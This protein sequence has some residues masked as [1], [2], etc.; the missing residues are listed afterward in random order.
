MTNK[1]NILEYLLC[2]SF[3]IC[4]GSS[5]GVAQTTPD[6]GIPGPYAV[7]KLEY[8]FGDLAYTPPPAAA[9]PANMEV[10]GSVHF[11]TNLSTGPYPVLLFLHGRHSTCWETSD[12]STALEWPCPT[13]W[14]SITSYEGYDYLARNMA[15]H[16]Y[17]VISISANAINAIDNTLPDDG[18][19]ARGVLVQHHLDLWNTWNTVGGAPFDTLFIGKLNMRNI[20]T[21][22]HSRGGEGVIYNAQYNAS[23]GSPYGIK[24]VL[25]LA[26][27]DFFRHVLNGI[28]LLDVAPYCDGDVSDLEGVHFYDDARYNDTND[29]APKHT[30]LFM[31]ADHDFFNTVWTPYLYPAGGADDWLYGF[32]STDPQ[33][34]PSAPGTKRLDTTTQQAALTAYLAAFYRIYIGHETQ[35]NPILQVSDIIP[36]ASSMLDS[37]QVFVSYHPA[38][39]DRLDVNRTDSLDRLTTNTLE[40]AV[41]ETGLVSSAICGGGLTMAT[42]DAGVSNDQ[43]PHRGTATIAGLGQM[44]MRWSDSAEWYQNALPVAYQNLTPYLT[45][46]FRASEDFKE[47]TTDTNV[48][49]TVQLVDSIGDTSNQVVGNHT[50]S[51]FYQPGTQPTDLPKEV[52][53]TISIPLS[54]FTGIDKTKVRYIRFKFN[55][56]GAGAVVISDLAFTNP[57]CGNFTAFFTDSIAHTGHKVFFTNQSTSYGQDS[58]VW[59]WNFGDA[60]S[61]VN[62]TS[63]QKSPFHIYPN[64]E[65][66]NPCLYVTSYRKNGLVCSDSFCTQA[67]LSVAVIN[68][69]NI[70]IMPNPAKDYIQVKGAAS[71]DVLT[72]I[73]L[74]GEVV[75]TATLRQSI[76]Q[77]PQNL[78]TGIYYAIVTTNTGRIYNKLLITR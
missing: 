5:R 49:F 75:L 52:F 24:A 25:T 34:G 29:E 54:T 26:P 35:F 65:S 61:G 23:L 59:K 38:R 3:F 71:T 78:A 62:D 10:C 74:Y 63:T 4:A 64:A 30:I 72:L 17:I 18:M 20:G 7:S 37:S 51:L 57:L 68:E 73:D 13:G 12:S 56:T 46:Q 41:T 14:Q 53:N 60:A 22:G 8:N 39:A 32:S 55:K 21:M 16:G 6:P 11:P 28:P 50:H 1:K 2:V 40:G 47:T 15:S 19:N 70:T 67:R 76:I 31:G 69:N 43:L 44:R 27:V 48:N 58:L 42:C 9:F 77:L 45:L 36:P 66:Y 33:C